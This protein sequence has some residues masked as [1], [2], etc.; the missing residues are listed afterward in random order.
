MHVGKRWSAPRILIHNN[1]SPDGPRYG[2]QETRTDE[3]DQTFGG[4][5]YRQTQG[6][7]RDGGM[8]AAGR[9]LARLRDELRNTE[10]FEN[11]RHAHA[12]AG[13]R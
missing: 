13:V 12:S 6:C 3:T 10:R 1:E 11:V 8:L 7:G 9:P 5:D 2:F 4:A